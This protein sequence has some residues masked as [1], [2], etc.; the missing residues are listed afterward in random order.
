ML[1]FH[2][3]NFHQKT[4]MTF[5]ITIDWAEQSVS[6]N[7]TQFQPNYGVSSVLYGLYFSLFVH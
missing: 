6:N 3:G 1:N 5:D 2:R 7:V 4:F